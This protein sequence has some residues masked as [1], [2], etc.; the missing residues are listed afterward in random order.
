MSCGAADRCPFAVAE[1]ASRAWSIGERRPLLLA[2]ATCRT[3]S[4]M[5]NVSP[6]LQLSFVSPTVGLQLQFP[7]GTPV[8]SPERC[9]LILSTVCLHSGLMRRT[10]SL[11][12]FLKQNF[13]IMPSY[14][15]SV[16]RGSLHP[17]STFFEIDANSSVRLAVHTGA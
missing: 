14:C 17:S 11:S 7:S 2:P 6:C 9:R 3:P 12:P 8:S 1:S 16:K 10:C 5:R 15:N 13:L 4:T